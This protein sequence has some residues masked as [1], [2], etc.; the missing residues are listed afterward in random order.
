MKAPAT[1]NGTCW[2]VEGKAIT[3][4]APLAQLGVGGQYIH[5]KTGKVMTITQVDTSQKDQ[6]GRSFTIVHAVG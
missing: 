5:P 2:V 3:G 6:K 1:H 4:E